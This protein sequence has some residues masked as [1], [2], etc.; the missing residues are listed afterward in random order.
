MILVTAVHLIL[1]Q[2]LHFPPGHVFLQ[3]K[4]LILALA[5]WMRVSNC[6]RSERRAVNV[7]HEYQDFSKL[8]SHKRHLPQ[9]Y[10]SHDMSSVI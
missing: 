1:Y 8:A 3:I 2:L 5:G 6:M 7:M 10:E 9:G 4:R